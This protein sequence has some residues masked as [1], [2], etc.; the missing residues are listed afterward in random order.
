M[1]IPV[2]SILQDKSCQQMKTRSKTDLSYATITPDIRSNNHSRC[3]KK[4]IEVNLDTFDKDKRKYI[5]NMIEQLY[6][7]GHVIHK[8][9]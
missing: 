8:L 7:N 5:T 1:V 9:Q 6:L 2:N 4:V 3:V